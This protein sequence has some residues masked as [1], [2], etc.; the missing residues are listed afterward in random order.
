MGEERSRRRFVRE[1]A[2]WGALGAFGGGVFGGG[3]LGG[4]ALAGCGA[5]EE[6]LPDVLFPLSPFELTDQH[7]ETFRSSSLEGKVWIASFL[8]TSC[9][10]ACPL[11]ASQLTNI[12]ARLEGNPDFH[13][14]SV[15][16]DPATDT[17]ARLTE[18][19]SR[20]GGDAQWTLLTGSV[21]DVQAVTRRA[22]FQPLP[23]RQVID[24]AP[25]FDILHGTGVLVFDRT[26]HCRGLYATSASELETLVTLLRRLLAA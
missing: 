16:V 10:Q 17:P 8:F 13:M 19:A 4:G 11:L 5:H 7:G 24:R 6:P 25:G 12:R 26:L 21:D 15:S 14:L 1:L 22:F 3:A 18:Y 23:T 2:A 9:S 20:Y